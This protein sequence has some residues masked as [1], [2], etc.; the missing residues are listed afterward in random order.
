MSETRRLPEVEWITLLPEVE[1]I[2]FS[3]T[4]RRPEFELITLLPEFEW[5]T[6]LPPDFVLIFFFF[7]EG[8]PI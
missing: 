6:L 2:L 1:C 4:R 5:I 8:D 3:E 7:F